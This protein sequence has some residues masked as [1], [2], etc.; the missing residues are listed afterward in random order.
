MTL[1]SN[2]SNAI[3]VCASLSVLRSV[4]RGTVYPNIE[5]AVLSRGGQETEAVKSNVKAK[6]EI[7]SAMVG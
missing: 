5:T 2:Y 3:S 1:T 7:A 4:P 6:K